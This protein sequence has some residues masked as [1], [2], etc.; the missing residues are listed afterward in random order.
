MSHLSSS[1]ARRLIVLCDAMRRTQ[2]NLKL[3][4]LFKYV[5]SVLVPR[6][7]IHRQISKFLSLHTSSSKYR[8][9]FFIKWFFIQTSQ[10]VGF[11]T[12]KCG[13]ITCSQNLHD[14]ITWK[15]SLKMSLTGNYGLGTL[16]CTWLIDKP[17]SCLQQNAIFNIF[18]TLD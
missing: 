6:G 9:W 16:A 4:S 2:I 15:I 1:E 3:K 5:Y 17:V 8:I 13:N 10:K 18:D 11:A 7:L 12:V 14:I